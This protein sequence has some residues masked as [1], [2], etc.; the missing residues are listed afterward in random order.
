MTEKDPTKDPKV[1]SVMDG[2]WRGLGVRIK[3]KQKPEPVVKKPIS[4]QA[5]PQQTK[6]EKS[7]RVTLADEFIPKRTPE[8]AEQ[9]RVKIDRT[10]DPIPEENSGMSISTFVSLVLIALSLLVLEMI[11]SCFSKMFFSIS[12]LF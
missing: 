2:L 8:D 3:E 7:T 11:T 9:D 10:N 5:S 4:Q 1:K 12:K 6:Y